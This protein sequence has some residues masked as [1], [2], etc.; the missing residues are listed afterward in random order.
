M[1]GG[2]GRGKEE[3]RAGTYRQKPTL[4]ATHTVQT[5]VPLAQTS[6][7]TGKGRTIFADAE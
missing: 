6:R 5:C 4:Y 3:G 2:G 7:N 1:K